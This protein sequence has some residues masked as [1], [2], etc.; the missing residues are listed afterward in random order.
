MPD[1][2]S[3]LV[4]MINSPEDM[5]IALGSLVR[6]VNALEARCDD[7][8]TE[9]D[10]NK[11]ITAPLRWLFNKLMAGVGAAIVLAVLAYLGLG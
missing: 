11:R 6:R 3:T 7:Q 10:E 9:I 8:Q 1:N 5:K 2:D 4:E